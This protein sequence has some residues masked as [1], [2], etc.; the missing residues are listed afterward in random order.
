MNQFDAAADPMFDVFTE[1][2]DITPFTA[3]SNQ[4]PLDEVN[5]PPAKIKDPLLRR[6]ASLSARLDFSRVDAC[7]EETL[8]R[9]LWHAVKGSA[10]PYPARA[11]SGRTSGDKDDQ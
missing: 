10:V 7:P 3:V 2:P 5:P 8:N 9:I 6:Q 1:T 11:T 4:V